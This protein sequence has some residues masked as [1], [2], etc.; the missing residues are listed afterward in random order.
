VLGV[1]LGACSFPERIVVE[2][3]AAD[4]ET[5]TDAGVDGSMIDAMVSM[6]AALD[7]PHSQPDS[8]PDSQPDSM[9]DAIVDT[10]VDVL[11]CDANLSNDPLNCGACNVRCP[12]GAACQGGACT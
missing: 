10:G 8:M 12:A 5:V 11:T 4:R 7:V 6:D 2:D 3:A 1:V 9:P